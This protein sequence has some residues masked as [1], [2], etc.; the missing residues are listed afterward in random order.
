LK[1]PGEKENEKI[2]YDRIS[3]VWERF[4]TASKIDPILMTL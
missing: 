2:Y 4:V 3:G 1:N